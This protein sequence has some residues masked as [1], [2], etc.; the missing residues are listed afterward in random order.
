MVTVDEEVFVT[1]EG[2]KALRNLAHG[3]GLGGGDAAD[4][5]LVRFA[6]VDQRD[7]VGRRSEEALRFLDG[8]FERAI[9]RG[10]V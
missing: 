2:G 1:R 7:S 5:Q 3:D 6:H 10:R 8:D 9:G 4:G